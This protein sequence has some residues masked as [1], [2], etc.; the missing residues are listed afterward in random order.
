[1][2]SLASKIENVSKEEVS[3]RAQAWYQVAAEIPLEAEYPVESFM[4]QES[5]ADDSVA[6]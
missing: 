5:L 6:V 2:W 3:R 1:M 4:T